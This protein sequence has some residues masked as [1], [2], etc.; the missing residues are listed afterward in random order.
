MAWV[1]GQA[2][3]MLSTWGIRRANAA[4]ALTDF[5]KQ[6][7][8]QNF[9]VP[10]TIIPVSQ[11]VPELPKSSDKTPQ[12]SIV[13]W[14]A[15]V[16]S[17]KRPE[18][19]IEL[20]KRCTDLEAKFLMVGYP[21]DAKLAQ[22]MKDYNSSLENFEYIGGQPIETVNKLMEEASIFVSTSDIEG[23]PNTFIQAWMRKLPIL[24]LNYDP[25]GFIQKYNLGYFANGDFEAFVK[26][27]RE[28]ITDENLR[29]Q[30]GSNAREFAINNF[31]IKEAAKKYDLLLSSLIN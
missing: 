9:G 4:I 15:N 8:E 12:K 27:A 13:L 5:G 25:G 2:L 3:D 7:I 20:A 19:F 29:E 24:C 17:L 10:A 6:K 23:L 11:Y 1:A 26:K 22:E 18:L 21:Q 31:D 30:L 16:K 28:L 14:V